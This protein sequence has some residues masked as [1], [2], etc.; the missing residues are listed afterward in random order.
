MSDDSKETITEYR[1]N[2]CG[3]TYADRSEAVNC[4]PDIIEV[5]A[6]YYTSRSGDK[7]PIPALAEGGSK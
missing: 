5:E 2:V 4:H 7:I 6:R 1:C 3:S